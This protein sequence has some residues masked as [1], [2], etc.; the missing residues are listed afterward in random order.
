MI[1]YIVNIT[2]VAGYLVW[3]SAYHTTQHRL[4][5][6]L[7]A[8]RN[9]HP[10]YGLLLFDPFLHLFAPLSPPSPQSTLSCMYTYLLKMPPGNQMSVTCMVLS[11]QKVSID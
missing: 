5:P 2:S 9:G 7:G 11:P 4:A 6:K 1:I 8:T 10:I 3:P